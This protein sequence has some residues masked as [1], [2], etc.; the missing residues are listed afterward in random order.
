MFSIVARRRAL[1]ITAAARGWHDVCTAGR[2]GCA[3]AS[4]VPVALRA[5]LG[6]L[7]QR[8]LAG[9]MA[10]AAA[11]AGVGDLLAQ[12]SHIIGFD[13]A[14]R[15]TDDNAADPYGAMAG[16]RSSPQLMEGVTPET[17][18]ARTVRYTAVVGT[19]VGFVGELWFR[20]LLGPFPRWNVD[21]AARTIVDQAVFAPA[22]LALTIGLV[23]LASSGNAEYAKM[24]MRTET[25]PPVGTMWAFW[26][27][28]TAV[29]YLN[30]PTPWQP[31]FAVAL[32]ALWNAYILTRIHR[33]VA[34][35]EDIGSQI[36]AYLRAYRRQE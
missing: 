3:N 35:A 16:L 32:G 36:D 26:G 33:P 12:A 8:P 10:S 30:V 4:G 20:R 19:L 24:R 11:A 17:G 5:Y 18:L 13:D 22:I 7:R 14:L 25:L 15:H 27:I 23:T 34:P 9:A 6:F 31:L 1:P 2:L 28:G 21:V 29:S